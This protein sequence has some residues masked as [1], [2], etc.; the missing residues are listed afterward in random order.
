MYAALGFPYIEL[1]LVLLGGGPAP[2]RA[3][4]VPVAA[5]I[6]GPRSKSPKNNAAS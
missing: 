6:D 3:P 4:D 5:K 2:E 1:G